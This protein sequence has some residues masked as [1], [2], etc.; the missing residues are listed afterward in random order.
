M[1][2]YDVQEMA[3][4]VV[5]RIKAEYSSLNTLNVMIMG[6]TG[7]GKSTLINNM[8]NEPLAKTGIGKP[9]TQKINRLTKPGVPLTIYDTPG[10]ELGGENAI[11]ALLREVTGEIEKGNRSGD[12]NRAIHCIWYCVS[13]TSH[14]FEDAEITFLRR[15]LD[16]TGKYHV[17]VIIVLT[18]S[19]SKPDA[20]AMRRAIARENLNVVNIV[21]VL[22][23]D[24]TINSC[25]VKAYG[26]DRLSELV[27]NVLQN[28]MKKT[29]LRVQKA[30]L[31]LKHDRAMAIVTSAATAAA[32]T[33]MTPIPFSDAP[34]L[35]T[36]Q[37]AM[38]ASI[39]AVYGLPIEKATIAAIISS[40]I[41][42]AGTTAAGKSIVSNVLKLIPGVGSAVGG[43]ISAVTAG[44][45][46]MALGN[47]YIIIMEKIML[48]E[49]KVTDLNKGKGKKEIEMIFTEQL[50][51]SHK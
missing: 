17:P 48:G 19:Y 27:Y 49:I 16:E 32:A 9:V 46:T 14:R 6:K 35:I 41:G 38:L 12:I 45:L 33:G 4:N 22:A 37:S 5:E 18:Q 20:E 44:G 15:F 24:F 34:L 25:V 39:T 51:K 28:E 2:D 30:C 8:F 10:L 7:V 43:A 23:E 47:A 11:N 40:L 42:T 29:F 31:K 50:H 3:N 1:A 26:L 36:A 21:P 13:T